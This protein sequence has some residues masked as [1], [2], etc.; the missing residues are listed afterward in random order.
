M[1]H[2]D[3]RSSRNIVVDP[4]R[5]ADFQPHA[6]V[7]DSRSERAVHHVRRIGILVVEDG[8][9]EVVSAEL[10]RV[11]APRRSGV[12]I[13]ELDPHGKCSLDRRRR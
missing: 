11:P 8:V 1:I 10:R 5:V 6:S 7:G 9:E 2:D 13:P 3:L 4:S 12:K